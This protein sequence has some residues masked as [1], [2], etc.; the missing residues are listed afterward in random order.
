VAR[1]S[2]SV[3]WAA[4]M[5]AYDARPAELLAT[6]QGA[7]VAPVVAM[8]AGSIIEAGLPCQA[9][10]VA[11]KLSTSMFAAMSTRSL[12]APKKSTPRM[13]KD[14]SACRK[15]HLKVSRQST[16]ATVPPPSTGS[17]GN[18]GR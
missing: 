6:P 13:E 12:L 10:L 5:E 3:A 7:S 11:S 14:T 15:D 18:L 1:G 2:L 4:V 17:G 16:A 9:E 8:F